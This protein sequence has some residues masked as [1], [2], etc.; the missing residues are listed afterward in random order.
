MNAAQLI[1]ALKALPPETEVYTDYYD[2]PR[3]KSYRCSIEGVEP[4]GQLRDWEELVPDPDAID[5]AA[6]LDTYFKERGV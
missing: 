1:E 2:E 6:A 3:N 4:D 5:W